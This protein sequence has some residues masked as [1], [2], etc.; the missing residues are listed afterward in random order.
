[1]SAWPLLSYAGAYALL[2]VAG[3]ACVK[4]EIATGVHA[5]DSP[6]GYGRFL[7]E[8]RV[9]AGLGLVC[10]SA[11][12]LFRALSLLEFSRMI[13]VSIGMNFVL[14]ALVG[15]IFFA[16]SFSLMKLTGLVLML[17]GAVLTSIAKE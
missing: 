7:L 4:A 16:E 17:A 11:L 2:N 14:A 12:V 6:R 5:F 3:A 10:L 8:W 15:R 9:L 13:P 1:M